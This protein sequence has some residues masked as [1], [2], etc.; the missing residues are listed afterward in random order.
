MNASNEGS[1]GGFSQDRAAVEASCS[2]SDAAYAWIRD[3]ILS[4]QIEAG[5]RLRQQHLASQLGVSQSTVREALQRLVLE[6]FAVSEP[7]RGVTAARVSMETLRDLYDMRMLLEGLAVKLATTRLTPQSL[8]ELHGLLPQTRDSLDPASREPALAA[9]RLFH[10]T[11]IAASGRSHLVRVLEQ[12]WQ[13]IEPYTWLASGQYW[14]EG[15][16][17]E[18]RLQKMDLDY[19]EHVALLEALDRRDAERARETAVTHVSHQCSDI[20]KLIEKGGAGS[21]VFASG[22]GPALEDAVLAPDQT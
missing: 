13:L 2:R 20:A 4:G 11:I 1:H 5:G 22:E 9:N 3:A 17:R 19:R 8:K 7:Y 21:S 16:P 18:E 10:R 14:S 12:I 6:G 15:T